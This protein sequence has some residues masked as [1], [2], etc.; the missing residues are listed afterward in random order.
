MSPSSRLSL[1][2]VWKQAQLS[3]TPLG[4]EWGLW[5]VAGRVEQ[6]LRPGPDCLAAQDWRVLSLAPLALTARHRCPAQPGVQLDTQVSSSSGPPHTAAQGGGVTA[7]NQAVRPHWSQSQ[8]VPTWLHGERAL[9]LSGPTSSGCWGCQR[10]A[11]V[12]RPQRGTGSCSHSKEI[13][14]RGP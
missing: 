11:S 1:Q 13:S 6:G 4:Q 10:C 12:Q 14:S 3:A 2:W 7:P 9:G 8:A 5:A